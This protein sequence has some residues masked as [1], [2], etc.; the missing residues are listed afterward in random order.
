MNQT[1]KRAAYRE[2]ALQDGYEKG[3]R[4]EKFIINLFNEH[5]FKL[6]NWRKSEIFSESFNAIDH[7]NPDIEMELI[8]TG[9]EKYRSNT[10]QVPG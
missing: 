3:Q 7:W 2:R 10:W 8:F 1:L 9:K 6:Q 5:Y 4:F